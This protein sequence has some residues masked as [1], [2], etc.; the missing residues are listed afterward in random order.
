MV[1]L[2]NAGWVESLLVGVFG[3]IGSLAIGVYVR[4]LICGIGSRQ[5]CLVEVQN[6]I[7]SSHNY[8]SA[9]KLAVGGRFSDLI[10]GINFGSEH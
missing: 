3:D 1:V 7:H 4:V 6:S 10:A 5:S 2:V 9:C 8:N